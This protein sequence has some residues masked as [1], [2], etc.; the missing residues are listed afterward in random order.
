MERLRAHQKVSH[1]IQPREHQF[2]ALITSNY[3]HHHVAIEIANLILKS[4][5]RRFF[6]G[7]PWDR[8]TS[9]NNERFTVFAYVRCVSGTRWIIIFCVMERFSWFCS[10]GH[11]VR[12][13]CLLSFTISAEKWWCDY[14]MMRKNCWGGLGDVILILMDDDEWMVTCVRDGYLVCCWVIRE[15]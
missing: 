15:K 1:A 6:F 14:L 11:L 4:N 13:S 2:V 3:Y 10:L 8:K 5:V 12:R 9:S 7:F